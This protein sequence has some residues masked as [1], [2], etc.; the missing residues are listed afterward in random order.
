VECLVAPFLQQP[1]LVGPLL[2]AVLRKLAAPQQAQQQLAGQP[3]HWPE[4]AAA[5]D[6]DPMAWAFTQKLVGLLQGLASSGHQQ[7]CT[8][9]FSPAERRQ[10]KC[11]VAAAAVAGTG[12]CESTGQQQHSIRI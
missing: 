2:E 1:G 4:A 5:Y 6:P 10:A 12:C 11:S 7:Q 3:T 8:A 9:A